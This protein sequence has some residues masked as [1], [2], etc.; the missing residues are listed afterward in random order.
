MV[1]L[2]SWDDFLE[3][4]VQLFRD[5]PESVSYFLLYFSYSFCYYFCLV[6]EKLY[7]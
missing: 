5:D 1:Y 4:S 2:T 3:Q 6:A 7:L